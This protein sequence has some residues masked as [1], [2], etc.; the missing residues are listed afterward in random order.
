MLWLL[1]LLLFLLLLLLL[2]LLWLPV[3]IHALA[4]RRPPLSAGATQ[5]ALEGQGAAAMAAMAAMAPAPKARR[6][7]SRAVQE[8]AGCTPC[9]PGTYEL[10]GR[11]SRCVDKS[12]TSLLARTASY[13]E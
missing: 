4:L 1:L 6:P 3:A 7:A 2:L 10:Y 5:L 8:N 9:L 12:A 13:C 11:A